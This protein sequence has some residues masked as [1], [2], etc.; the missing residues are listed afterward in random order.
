MNFYSCVWLY[1][2][3]VSKPESLSCNSCDHHVSGTIN[4]F[5]HIMF[6]AC[7]NHAIVFTCLILRHNIK[8]DYVKQ[9]Q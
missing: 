1:H 5:N 7:P 3:S 9:K 8:C 4:L 2:V 6:Q